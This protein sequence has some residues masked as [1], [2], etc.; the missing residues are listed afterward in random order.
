M[1]REMSCEIASVCLHSHP[2]RTAPSSCLA[3]SVAII[4]GRWSHLPHPATPAPSACE[5]PPR[6]STDSPASKLSSKMLHGPVPQRLVER[7]RPQRA[8]HIRCKSAAPQPR[9]AAAGRRNRH[10]SGLGFWGLDQQR[11]TPGPGAP[12]EP[13]GTH[14]SRRPRRGACCPRTTPA[15]CFP[16]RWLPAAASL[17]PSLRPTPAA[18]ATA[19]TS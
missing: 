7:N 10:A 16:P 5:A 19:A 17:R 13:A 12:R 4:W 15:A 6:A 1:P 9:R 8:V 11:S 18:P 3:T 2:L 14:P